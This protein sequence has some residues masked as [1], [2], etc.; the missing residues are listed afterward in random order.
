MSLMFG[1]SSHSV[2]FR[3]IRQAVFTLCFLSLVAPLLFAQTAKRS[4][5]YADFDS[6]RNLQGSQ[7]SRDGKFVAY[8]MQAQDG[9]GELFV[10]STT[11]STDWRAPRGYH[12][13][14]PPPDASDPAATMAFQ[15]LARLLRPSFSA[16]GKYVMFIIEPTK[17][18]T[19]KA[20][21]DKKK[22][23]DM[24]K[25]ALGILDTASGQVSKVE[26]VK[27]FQVPEDGAGYVAI[28]K[29]AAKEERPSTPPANANTAPAANPAANTS[30]ANTA[31]QPA[32][33]PG[34]KKKEY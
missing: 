3:R 30:T 5:T 25:N 29:E 21:K 28:L 17:A 34:E 1:R 26:G 16:D 20:R 12:P 13:P 27:S 19:L 33:R 6:W 31:G 7:I 18:E 22:P 14:T 32:T 15:A 2:A 10:H 23:E 4:L 24:P 8:V 11:G 9:D